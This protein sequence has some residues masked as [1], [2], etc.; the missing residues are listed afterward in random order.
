MDAVKLLLRRGAYV[1]SQTTEMGSTA[2]HRAG[3]AG[4]A[5]VVGLLLDAGADVR[6]R[7][8]DGLTALERVAKQRSGMSMVGV[9]RPEVVALLEQAGK[10][11]SN[12]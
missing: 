4:H 2:L 1:D 12:S 3:A 8:C 11:A 10:T 9:G 7:D 6:R 5:A